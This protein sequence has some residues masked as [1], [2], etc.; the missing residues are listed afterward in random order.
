MNSTYTLI[1][2]YYNAK[3]FIKRCFYEIS[4]QT[5]L[6]SCI[7]IV[8]DGSIQ[9]QKFDI[10]L[11]DK[12]LKDKVEIK[13]IYEKSNK[14]PEIIL[15]QLM[16]LITTNY[17]KICAIDDRFE[18]NFAEESLKILNKYK[19]VGYV[20]SKAAMYFED[21]NKIKKLNV[22]FNQNYYTGKEFSKYI[23]NKTIKIYSPTIIYK[24]EIFKKDNIFFNN[25]GVWSDWLNN[26]YI[27]V[28][29]GVCYVDKNLAYY[30]IHKN[31]YNKKFNKYNH[32]L[33]K[34]IKIY[35]EDRRLYNFLINNY[36]LYDLSP[37]T[38]IKLKKTKLHE[39][40]SFKL[41][42]KSFKY[43]IW[44]KVKIFLPETILN[45]FIKTFS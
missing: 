29:H 1:I 10:N 15:K 9:D 7:F 35:N 43:Y 4:T 11:V 33:K 26:I 27:G 25:Y 19:D 40:Y 18:K 34:I 12:S 37:L 5:K 8:D 13:I 20:F 17:F 28:K 44:N 31:Q 23:K 39:I 2:P 14:G 41:L 32:Y 36:V 21:N 22:K 6:P 38:I 45:F 16:P 30:S 24:T 3:K 42:Y